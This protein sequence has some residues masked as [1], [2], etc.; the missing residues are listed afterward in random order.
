MQFPVPMVATAIDW[1]PK[2]KG[3]LGVAYARRIAFDE[4]VDTSSK[5]QKSFIIIWNFANS[6]QPQV[7]RCVTSSATH[8]LTDRAGGD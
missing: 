4:R 6:L 7:P 2:K 8:A 1:H 5:A 3:V